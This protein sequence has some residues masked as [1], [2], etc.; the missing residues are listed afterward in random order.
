[1]EVM[2]DTRFRINAPARRQGLAAF[3]ILVV[4]DQTRLMLRPRGSET[5]LPVR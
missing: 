2:L 4:V 5:L 3:D 1:M